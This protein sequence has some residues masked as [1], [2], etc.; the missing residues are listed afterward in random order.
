LKPSGAS[1]G[2]D[3]RIQVPDRGGQRRRKAV[4][5]MQN[6]KGKMAGVNP[7]KKKE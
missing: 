6:P 1:I 5:K 4:K 7:G 3:S 2:G